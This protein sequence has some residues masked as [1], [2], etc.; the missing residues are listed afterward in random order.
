MILSDFS[1]HSTF[2]DSKKNVECH[3]NL[4][5]DAFFSLLFTVQFTTINLYVYKGFTCFP[6]QY[7]FHINTHDIWVEFLPAGRSTDLISADTCNSLRLVSNFDLHTQSGAS[8]Q[9]FALREIKLKNESGLL[10]EER[11]D[12]LAILSGAGHDLSC[13]RKIS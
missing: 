10:K 12:V 5:L 2:T 3:R 6:F 7:H 13:T 1:L 11:R 8:S 9:A 4:S